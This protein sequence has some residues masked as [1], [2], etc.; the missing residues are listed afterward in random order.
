MFSR[1]LRSVEIGATTIEELGPPQALLLRSRADDHVAMQ[2]FADALHA[3]LPYPGAARHAPENL[4]LWTAPDQW[5][6]LAASHVMEQAS[7]RL[8]TAA[9]NSHAAVVDVSDALSYVA[10]SGAGAEKVLSAGCSVDLKSLVDD[11]VIRAPLALAD[12]TLLAVETRRR[13]M[14][15]IERPMS[16]YLWSW[17]AD[18]ALGISTHT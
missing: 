5:L 14:L 7:L 9:A 16:P 8:R 12:V 11:R 15:I 4:T 6:F 18:T 10:L 3:P 1:G 13:F 17:L 2:A